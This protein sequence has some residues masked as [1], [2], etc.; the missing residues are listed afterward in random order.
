MYDDK[1]QLFAKILFENATS[2]MIHLFKVFLTPTP[3]NSCA[4]HM[5]ES[6]KRC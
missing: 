4:N 3:K 5:I 1:K 6:F 2:S